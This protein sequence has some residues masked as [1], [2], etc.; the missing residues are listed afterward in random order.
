[1]GGSF[2]GTLL[3]GMTAAL[4]LAWLTRDTPADGHV[5]SAPDANRP[6]S[7]NATLMRADSGVPPDS[8]LLATVL[9]T[10][11]EG[12]MVVD[13]REHLVYANPAARTLLE[14]PERAGPGRPL[15]EAVRS[16]GIESAMQAAFTTGRM[17][18]SELELPRKERTVALTASPLANSSAAG[19]VLVLQDVTDLR[20][21]ERVRRE[22]VSN[23]SHELKT[24]LT[25]IQ[26]YA[27]TLADGAID[28]PDHSRKFLERIVEQAERLQALI[29]DLL[30][31]ARI[32]SQDSTVH[33]EPL[34]LA[35]PATRCVEEHQ[36]AAAGSGVTLTLECRGEPTVLAD[37]AGLRQ[38]AD[39]L[40]NNALKYTPTGGQVTVTVSGSDGCGVLEVADTGVGIPR[41]EQ[42]RVFERFYRVDRARTRAVGGT[43]LGLAIVKHLV[44][45]YQGRIDL[46][47]EVG[48]GSRF[49]VRIPLANTP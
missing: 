43:G 8:A 32:E 27:D 15:L 34:D 31:L 7:P 12:V 35:E 2:W 9:E 44:Q 16:P 37:A 36:A 17:H 22:F 39:N 6:A 45:A 13:A 40:V 11:I 5:P 38:I 30:Q 46:S 24:P 47:S 33:L 41:D 1:S 29:A 4:A 3:V 19:V 10:M 26:A 20:R 49:V 42:L 25:H 48:R 28:D 23:V 14:I 21:L 18:T